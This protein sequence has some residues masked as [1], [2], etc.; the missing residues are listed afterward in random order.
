MIHLSSEKFPQVLVNNSP[1]TFIVLFIISNRSLEIS[2]ISQS[3]RSNWTQVWKLKMSCVY[4][5]SVSTS[6]TI[7]IHSEM[8]SALD[9][10]NF[11]LSDAHLSKLSLNIKSSLLCNKQE[12]A[13]R[14]VQRFVSHAN[15]CCEY[16]HSKS[17]AHGSISSTS[18]GFH[19]INKIMFFFWYLKWTPLKLIRVDNSAVIRKFFLIFHSCKW[20]MSYSWLRAIEPTS[21]VM[22]T[23]NS[24]RSA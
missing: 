19:A 20:M 9:H 5:N 21:L 1:I 13:I 24:K 16:I 17:F 10:T 22:S 3:V 8:H 2:R 18:H 23:R 12:I 7:Y 4:F 11:A 6:R 15:I 14:R